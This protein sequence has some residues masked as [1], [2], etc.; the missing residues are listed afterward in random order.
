MGERFNTLFYLLIIIKRGT[1]A[2]LWCTPAEKSLVNTQ[3]D[4]SSLMLTHNLFMCM[5]PIGQISLTQPNK[6]Y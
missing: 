3:H 6:Q 5:L 2:Q 1:G 4:S